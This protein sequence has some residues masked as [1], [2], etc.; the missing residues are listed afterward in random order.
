MEEQVSGRRDRDVPTSGDRPE[1]VQAGRTGTAEQPVEGG[2]T[3]AYD[4]GQCAFGLPEPDGP[5]Q[6]AEVRQHLAHLLFAARVNGDQQED[7]RRGER[8]EDRLRVHAPIISRAPTVGDATPFGP[9]Q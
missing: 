4:A 3:D 5:T 6:P 2:G 1:R 7:R 8:G 9:A